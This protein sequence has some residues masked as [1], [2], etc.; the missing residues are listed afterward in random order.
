MISGL[1]KSPQMENSPSARTVAESAK[2]NSLPCVVRPED[3]L[4]PTMCPVLGIPLRPGIGKPHAGSPSLDRVKPILGY[5]L[6]NT[7]VISLRAN[8]LKRDGT[9]EEHLKIADWMDSMLKCE[10]IEHNYEEV[11]D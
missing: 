8:L 11:P 3:I 6:E 9:A 5:T 2:K 7:R 1:I 4:V 10:D